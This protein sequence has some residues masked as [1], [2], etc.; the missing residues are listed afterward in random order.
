MQGLIDEEKDL[1]FEI[2]PELFSIGT[3]T[4]LEK[5]VSL[6]SVGVSKIRSIEESISK[7]RTSNQ[8]ATKVVPSTMKLED[9]YVKPKVSLEDKVYPKTYYHHSQDDIQV[10]ET[11]T[12]IQVQNF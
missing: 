2:E 6:L 1:I 4:L 5:I 9:F 11:T 12:K 10:D 8:I 3:I 7:Q